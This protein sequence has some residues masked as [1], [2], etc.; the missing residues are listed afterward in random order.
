MDL[1]LM[2]NMHMMKTESSR[3][4]GMNR[5]HVYNLSGGFYSHPSKLI[6]LMTS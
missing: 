1:C 2:E 4:K 3:S 6:T 5:L